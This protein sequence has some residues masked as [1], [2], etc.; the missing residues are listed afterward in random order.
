[1]AHLP[2]TSRHHRGGGEKQKQRWLS[3]HALLCA[4]PLNPYKWEA[5]VR[6]QHLWYTS[7]VWGV[8]CLGIAPW[9]STGELC[10]AGFSHLFISTSPGK[11][12]GK[13]F[14]KQSC[15]G[16]KNSN[17]DQDSVQWSICLQFRF[18]SRWSHNG[19]L[20]TVSST[21]EHA[22]AMLA[23]LQNDHIIC[24]HVKVFFYIWAE[25]NF[26]NDSLFI[27]WKSEAMADRDFR[28]PIHRLLCLFKLQWL[29]WMEQEC[30]SNWVCMRLAPN[31]KNVR[32]SEVEKLFQ[33]AQ[34]E[35]KNTF[36][37]YRY[38]LELLP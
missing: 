31:A 7:E 1:M 24:L 35:G 38:L 9:Q 5:V 26:P 37:V 13:S 28:Q 11:V 12:Y 22:L 27:V 20:F 15:G 8:F 21:L 23:Q 18:K 36:T 34:Q 30:C 14:D 6:Y 33:K 3:L 25:G 32:N 2:V 17:S 29:R 19:V 16:K 10:F 4:F